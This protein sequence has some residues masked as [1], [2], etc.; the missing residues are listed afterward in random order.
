MRGPAP[1]PQTVPQTDRDGIRGARPVP[2]AVQGRQQAWDRLRS[3]GPL[4]TAR[5]PALRSRAA[6]VGTNACAGLDPKRHVGERAMT[7]GG[8]SVGRAD[9]GAAGEVVQQ[10]N[11]RH[12]APEPVILEPLRTPPTPGLAADPAPPS[13]C[14]P[15]Q[16]APHALTR[17]ARA[18]ACRGAVVLVPGG[19]RKGTPGPAPA[20]RDPVKPARRNG[21]A[22]PVSQRC[23]AVLVVRRVRWGEAP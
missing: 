10:G 2:R 9:G 4:C 16:S 20:R 6:G 22:A 7:R 5:G 17:C 8:S 1:V 14:G 13:S 12:V 18:A 19:R 11:Q 3:V 23:E 15:R 21:R